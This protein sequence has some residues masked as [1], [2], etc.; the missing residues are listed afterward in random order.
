MIWH[1]PLVQGMPA[2]QSLLCVHTWPYSAQTVPPSGGGGGGPPSGGGGGG[3]DP[4]SGV[5]LGGVQV[6]LEAPGGMLQDVPAQQSAVVVHA[7][8]VGTHD[9]PPQTKGFEVS[10]SGFGTHGLLQQS[11]LDAQGVPAGGGFTLQS[12]SVPAVQRGM[13]SRSS[14]QLSG[15]VITVPAQQRSVALHCITAR[16]QMAPAGLQAC[17]LSHRP[18]V[19]PAALLQCTFVIA[20]PEMFVEPGVPGAPQQ[21]L[22]A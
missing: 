17:P 12:T 11:A 4:P 19:A 20:P 6:P 5:P 18:T 3:G 9:V 21:S 14:L 22:S 2:Q 15:C 16:R 1:R 7:P 8:A 13:P 10:G